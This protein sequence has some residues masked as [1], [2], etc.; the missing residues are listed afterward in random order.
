MSALGFA[1]GIVDVIFVSV[2]S[3]D[4]GFEEGHLKEK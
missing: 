2:A 4:V 3:V 1:R